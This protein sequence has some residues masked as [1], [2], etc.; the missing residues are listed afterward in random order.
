M[1]SFL[2]SLVVDVEMLGEQTLDLGIV[3][4]SNAHLE[5]ASFLLKEPFTKLFIAA[6]GEAADKMRNVI[7]LAELLVVELTLGQKLGLA[8]LRCTLA[9][10][11]SAFKG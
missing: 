3:K 6:V 4:I 7:V 9:L 10:L 11:Q 2:E 5:E 8:N 1:V